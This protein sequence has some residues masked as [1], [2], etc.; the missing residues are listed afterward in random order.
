MGVEGTADRDPDRRRVR[1]LQGRDGGEQF[2]VERVGAARRLRWKLHAFVNRP[3][4]VAADDRAGCPADVD[5]DQLN[6]LTF[7]DPSA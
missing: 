4:L 6:A 1:R 2:G 3:A 5:A 7:P